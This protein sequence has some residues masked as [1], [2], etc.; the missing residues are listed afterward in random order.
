MPPLS[1]WSIRASLVYFAAGITIGFLILLN[2]ASQ[3]W[4]VVWSLLHVH[5]EFIWIGFVV[6]LTLGVA[7]WIFPRTAS[8]VPRERTGLAVAAFVLLNLGILMVCIAPFAHAVLARLGRLSELAAAVAFV[9]H[10]W[11][12]IYPFGRY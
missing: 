4:P 5:I 10:V 7:Y 6:Q 8:L 12:R 1:V 3:G 9:G 11:P 2:K